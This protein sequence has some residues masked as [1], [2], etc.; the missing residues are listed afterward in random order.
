MRRS[1]LKSSDCNLKLTM[2]GNVIDWMVDALTSISPP[3]L[4]EIL[5]VVIFMVVTIVLVVL[6]IRFS[7]QA[8]IWIHA[9]CSHTLQE[10]LKGDSAVAP[11]SDFYKTQM[12]NATSWVE[13]EIREASGIAW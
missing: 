3:L 12:M 4:Q 9:A 11:T 10:S 8:A 7:W 1:K 6:A 13:G 5:A 2:D